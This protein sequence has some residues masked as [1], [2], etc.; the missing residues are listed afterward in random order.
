MQI[1]MFKNLIDVEDQ[2][3]EYRKC[4]NQIRL[5][6]EAELCAS[7]VNENAIKEYEETAWDS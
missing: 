3:D 2:C 4:L 7:Y 1:S 5:G 6:I